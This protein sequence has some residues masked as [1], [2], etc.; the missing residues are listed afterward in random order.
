MSC[1]IK[2]IVYVGLFSV[3]IGFNFMTGMAA[4]NEFAKLDVGGVAFP[5][6]EQLIID[7]PSNWDVEKAIT[8]SGSIEITYYYF[9]DEKGKLAFNLNYPIREIGYESTTAMNQRT[10]S[11]DAGVKLSV[12]DRIMSDDPNSGFVHYRW[13]GKDPNFWKD[14]FEI[15]VPF[16][17]ELFARTALESQ[18]GQGPETKYK[19]YQEYKEGQSFQ[20]ISMDKII[21]SIATVI[22]TTK[23]DGYNLENTKYMIES[24]NITVF[25]GDKK[26][27]AD[28]QFGL[29]DTMKVTM[30]FNSKATVLDDVLAAVKVQGRDANYVDRSMIKVVYLNNS[31]AIQSNHT[32]GEPSTL[33]AKLNQLLA[34][35]LQMLQLQTLFGR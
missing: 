29:G 8:K 9:F 22:S 7:L 19:S 26:I 3:L 20:S 13:T 34:L 27:I 35:L 33:L 5:V 6:S 32:D 17:K 30:N 11:T 28:V 18:A 12:V 2:K 23:K 4:A 16:R 14:S 21:T 1:S 31:S 24:A 25:E 15:M 10:L